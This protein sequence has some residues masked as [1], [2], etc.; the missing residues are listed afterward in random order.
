MRFELSEEQE[1]LRRSARELVAAEWPLEKTRAF[2]EHDA[3]GHDPLAWKHLAEMGYLSLLLPADAGGQGLGA[4][5]LAVVCEEMGRACV[6]GPFLE[7]VLAGALLAEAGGHDP[8]VRRITSGD[9]VV[10][11]A[12]LDSPWASQSGPRLRFRDGRVRGRKHFV[13]YAQEAEA[14]LVLVADGVAL[15]RAPFSTTPQETLDPA[16]RF[17]AVDLDHPA[18]LVA[19]AEILERN[20]RLAAVGAAAML[21][22]L[23]DRS[24]EITLDYVRTRQTFGR[25]IGSFQALQHR[26]AD[27]WVRVESA[28]AAVYRGAWCVAAGD[29]AAPLAAATAKAYAGDTA[30]QATGEAI[31][32]HGG[33]GFTWEL[34]VHLYFKRVKTLEQMYGSTEAHVERALTAFGF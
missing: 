16:Q 9:A 28:R 5:E 19:N 21:L 6:P 32:M 7:T 15:A 14:L 29:P 12:R 10:T 2:I 33:I 27:T 18:E 31:Q 20:D 24:L 30:R 34:D 1:L 8:L 25:P 23:A 17:S 3:R 4:I 22:G 13:A 11:F 26:L